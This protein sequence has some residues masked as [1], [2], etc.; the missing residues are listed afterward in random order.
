MKD[1]QKFI[2]KETETILTTIKRMD[3]GGIGFIVVVGLD[4]KIIGVITDGDFRRSILKGVSLDENVLSITNR[5]FTYLNE[6]YEPS[7]AKEIFKNPDIRRIPVLQNGKLI[8]IIKDDYYISLKQYPKTRKVENIPVVIM[9]GGKGSRLEP[10]TKILP[11]PL[12]PVGDKAIIDHIMDEFKG[13]GIDEFYFTLN[14]K[15]EMIK[16]YFSNG[17]KKDLK[18]HFIDEPE[19]LGTAGSLSL[20]STEIAEDFF[21]TNC[22]IMVKADYAEVI[23]FHKKNKAMLTVISSLQHFKIPYGV[24]DFE[25]DGRIVKIVEKPE[26]S[27][28]INTGVYVMNRKCL[29]FIP[30]NESYNMT[31]LIYRLI[32]EGKTVQMYPVNESE[33]VDIGQWEQYTQVID[34]IQGFL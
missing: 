19:F 27:I 28:T 34:K 31:N 11:K 6:G 26:N 15:S 13:Y 22:D 7:E 9:A 4:E 5:N 23:D 14:Y 16:A 20:L 21:V 3:Q 18:L 25:K 1:I 30:K 33:Y 17:N 32:S 24:I 29:N 2:V 10:F 8:K 12:I